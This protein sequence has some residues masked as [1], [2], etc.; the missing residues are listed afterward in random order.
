MHNVNVLRPAQTQMISAAAWKIALE[1]SD[2]PTMLV[3]TRQNVPTL[4]QTKE[5]ALK[6]LNEGG[7]SLATARA[8]INQMAF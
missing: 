1:S 2:R 4:E 8:V 5:T 3:L 6:M 7:Y